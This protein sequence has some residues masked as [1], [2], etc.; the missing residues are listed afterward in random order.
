MNWQYKR[1]VREAIRN[2]PRLVPIFSSTHAIPEQIYQYDKSFF[3]CYNAV[4]ER[5]EVHSLEHQGDTIAFT[6]PYKKLDARTM[7]YLWK[8]DIRVHG[9]AIF[10]RIEEGE[11][12]ARREQEKARSR[13]VEDMAKE[14]QSMFAKSAW[15]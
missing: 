12:R 8:N 13:W 1:A 9:R 14:T 15:T 6:V 7:R 5:F 11:E 10:D 3:V 2:R 4:T